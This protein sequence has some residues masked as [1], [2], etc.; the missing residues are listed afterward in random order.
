MTFPFDISFRCLLPLAPF[1]L[2]CFSLVPMKIPPFLPPPPFTCFSSVGT[3]SQASKIYAFSDCLLVY[4]AHSFSSQHVPSLV[5]GAVLQ[6]LWYPW[7]I[8]MICRFIPLS[9]LLLLPQHLAWSTRR[10]IEVIF[11]CFPPCYN[12]GVWWIHVLWW[13]C[14]AS[15]IGYFDAPFFVQFS[16]RCV[17]PLSLSERG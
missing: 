2:F 7:K 17:S 5:A 3:S 16:E 4:S 8:S 6:T 11:F 12:I 1:C 9:Y 10:F 13:P 14:T 15:P